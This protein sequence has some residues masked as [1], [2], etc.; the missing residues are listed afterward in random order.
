[1]NTENAPS[2]HI[3]YSRGHEKEYISFQVTAAHGVWHTERMCKHL[4]IHCK[5]VAINEPLTCTEKRY[6]L[7]PHKHNIKTTFFFMLCIASNTCVRINTL[8]RSNMYIFMYAVLYLL[9]P[10]MGSTVI[11]TPFTSGIENFISPIA[12]CNNNN[13]IAV[14]QCPRMSSETHQILVINDL[15]NVCGVFGKDSHRALRNIHYLGK[16]L[17]YVCKIHIAGYKPKWTIHMYTVHRNIVWQNHA[18]ASSFPPRVCI[19]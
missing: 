1:M 5:C 17:K 10:N 9:H 11:L 13:K 18:C 8:L 19:R 7:M 2:Q 4:H 12:F 16:S 3:H 6:H 15:K 14:S